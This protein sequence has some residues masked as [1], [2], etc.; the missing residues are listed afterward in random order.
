[1]PE[2]RLLLHAG[3][4]ACSNP[5]THTLTIIMP[6]ICLP[7]GITVQNTALDAVALLSVI[8]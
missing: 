5:N 7:H 6:S 1:V 2:S 3:G 8:V 4:S